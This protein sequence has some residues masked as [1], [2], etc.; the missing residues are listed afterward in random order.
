MVSDHIG[1]NNTIG[2]YYEPIGCE[3][4]TM[5]TKKIRLKDV[6][7]C[8]KENK[9]LRER[10]V[11][12]IAGISSAQW[13]EGIDAGCYPKPLRWVNLEFWSESVILA[14]FVEEDE[15]VVAPEIIIADRQA[16]LRDIERIEEAAYEAQQDAIANEIIE[17]FT[18]HD[19]SDSDVIQQL[20]MMLASAL[21]VR[22]MNRTGTI[23]FMD[24]IIEH[25]RNSIILSQIPKEKM[26]QC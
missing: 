2:Y 12:E 18:S 4:N 7:K 9:L 13:R 20:S 17:I 1:K 8:I 25:A 22:A 15:E 16:I 19:L 14:L 26:A 10:E 6:Q 11:L 5:D 3:C 24:R 21:R 23:D